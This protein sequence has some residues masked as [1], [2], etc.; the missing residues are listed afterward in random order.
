[1]QAHASRR[2]RVQRAMSKGDVAVFISAP[3]LIRSNDV[4]HRFRQDSDFYYLTGFDEEEAALVIEPDR[5]ILYLRRRDP[6]KETWNGPMLGVD[7]AVA[8]LEIDEARDINSFRTDIPTLLKNRETLYYMFGRNREMDFFLLETS[9]RLLRRSRAG[10]FGPSKIVHSALL[11]HEMRL[12]KDRGEI[13]KMR[14][15]ADITADAHLALFEKTRVSMFEYE[16]ESIIHEAFRKRNATEAYPSIVAAGK[17]AC[18]LHYI[19]N[20]EKIGA[21]Q[22]ILVDA[23]AEKDYMNGDVTRTYP[24][25]KTFTSPQRDAY[26]VVLD[27]QLNAIDRTVTGISMEEVHNLTVRDLV[28]GLISLKVLSGTVDEN[29]E[30]GTYKKYYMHRTGHWLGLDVHDVG[31]YNVNGAPRKMEPGMICTVEPGLYFPDEADVPEHFR[32]IGIRIEDDV[33]VTSGKAEVLTARIPKSVKDIEA[34]RSGV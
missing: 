29:I 25:G 26:Q 32:G 20:D 16:L 31:S 21:D 10:D 11:L 24:S 1:M 15:A 30:N 19:K 22:L 9:D 2:E 8:T 28:G 27:A 33:L 3:S 7:R 12:V 17:N 14:L 6:E 5:C 34:I 23:G 13:D 18:I 4:H